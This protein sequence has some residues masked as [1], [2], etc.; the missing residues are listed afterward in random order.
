MEGTLVDWLD[1]ACWAK[2]KIGGWRNDLGVIRASYE[3]AELTFTYCRSDT[4]CILWRGIRDVYSGWTFS[5]FEL[6]YGR[7]SVWRNL[8]RP[9]V[10]FWL[11]SRRY[12][13]PI[14]HILTVV[15]EELACSYH[16]S[17]LKAL[18]RDKGSKRIHGKQEQ[19]Y[20]RLYK[21]EYALELCF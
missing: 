15:R 20:R 11:T 5:S 10:V 21:E 2:G 12:H 3:C 13:D 17:H 18:E 7:S 4:S 1:S 8:S 9:L 16:S 6:C 19:G 14:Y